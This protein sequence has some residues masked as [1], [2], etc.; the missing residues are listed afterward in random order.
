MKI[1][2][3]PKDIFLHSIRSLSIHPWL[4]LISFFLAVIIWFYVKGEGA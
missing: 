1:N 2:K 4:K 3:I